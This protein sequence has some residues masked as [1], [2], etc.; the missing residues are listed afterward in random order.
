[1]TTSKPK[2]IDEYITNFPSEIQEILEQ[3]RQ[4]IKKAAPDAK[5]KL[6]YAIPTFTLNRNLVH[7]AAFKNHIGFY[8]MPSGNKAFQEELSA[9]K[10]GKGSIQFPLDKPI[11]LNLITK[12]V[13]FR[14]EEN[15]E[16]IKK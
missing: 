14:V 16:K 5:E 12:I 13:K 10:S 1:M 8:A 7:F 6:S 4:T 9:Y 11:P 3:V 2:N 15:L